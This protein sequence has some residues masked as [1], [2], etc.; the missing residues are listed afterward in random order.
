MNIDAITINISKYPFFMAKSHLRLSN[1]WC[2]SE[3]NLLFPLR[4]QKEK[5]MVATKDKVFME[6]DKFLLVKK[7]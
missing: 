4:K 5:V 1:G 2:Q 3:T 7:I 6:L